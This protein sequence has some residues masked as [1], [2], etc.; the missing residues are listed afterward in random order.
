MAKY[1]NLTIEELESLNEDFVKFLVLNGITGED[2]VKLKEKEPEN[3]EGICSA[4]SD[5]VFTKILTNCKYLEKHLPKFLVS[6]F[7]DKQTM[8]LQGIE[9]AEST[10]I[11][12]TKKED[13]EKLKSSPIEGLQKIS[14]Q[15]DYSKNREEEIWDM[16]QN[17]FYISD[18]KMYMNLFNEALESKN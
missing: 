10:A 13:F 2:W 18:Q 12:F 17:G 5:V 7:C 4:F 3:A 6:I 15:K 8:Y 14:S 9:A 11:D 1:R 16:L